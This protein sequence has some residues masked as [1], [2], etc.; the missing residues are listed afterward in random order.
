MPGHTDVYVHDAQVPNPKRPALNE[1]VRQ[2]TQEIQTLEADLGRAV[3]A[4]AERLLALRFCQYYHGP[5]D[6]FSIF[7]A[8]FH[9]PGTVQPVDRGRLAVWRMGNPAGVTSDFKG[10]ERRRM[11]A[12]RLLEK[13]YT[14]TDVVRRVG[15]HRQSVNRWAKEWAT[16]CRSAES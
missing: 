7:W 2:V 9:L 4:N 13:G 16:G 5:N 3:A 12:A 6:C 14:E 15:V 11:Q 10:L 1:K 8:L